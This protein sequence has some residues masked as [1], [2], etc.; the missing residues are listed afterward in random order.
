MPTDVGVNTAAVAAAWKAE[1][2]VVA[3][4]AGVLPLGLPTVLVVALEVGPADTVL[5][6]GLEVMVVDA[7]T[8]TLVFVAA[9]NEVTNTVAMTTGVAGS[10]TLAANLW[11]K[12]FC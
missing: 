6:I 3:S 12:L 2:I 9:G 10:V 8:G 11:R 4:S 1:A 7:P 5:S